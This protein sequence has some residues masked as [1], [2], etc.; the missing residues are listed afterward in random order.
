MALVVSAEECFEPER[1]GQTP[2]RFPAG[3]L[4]DFLALQFAAI[5]PLKAETNYHL[6]IF[7]KYLHGDAE[8]H[9]PI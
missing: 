2:I 9:H 7:E 8:Y 3:P 5:F 4:S 6:D 1:N